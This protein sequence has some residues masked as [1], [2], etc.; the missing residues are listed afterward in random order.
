MNEKT[1]DRSAECSMVILR[2]KKM[3]K[4][5]QEKLLKTLTVICQSAKEEH[6]HSD[7]KYKVTNPQQPVKSFAIDRNYTNWE[8]DEEQR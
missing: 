7:L 3:A 2:W 6:N 8:T 4:T 5:I 1:I